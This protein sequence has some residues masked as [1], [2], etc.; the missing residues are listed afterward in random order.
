M[1]N[2]IHRE[3]FR[4]GPFLKV[5][6]CSS[7]DETNINQEKNH[8]TPVYWVTIVTCNTRQYADIQ[9]YM[10][11]TVDDAASTVDRFAICDR[12]RGL[13]ESPTNTQVMWLCSSQQLTKLNISH[14]RVLSS[15]LRVQDTAR[16][17]GIVI[18]SQL[19]LSVHIAAVC[20]NGYYQLRQ[21]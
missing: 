4:V 9:V 15:C 13:V 21:L 7:D 10:N 14:V 18:D 2:V 12:G 19:S 20:Q 6:C 3:H 8:N 16:D 1:S 11:A 5:R 17:L